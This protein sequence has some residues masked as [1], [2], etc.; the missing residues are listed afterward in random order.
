[1]C[2]SQEVLLLGGKNRKVEKTIE[3]SGPRSLVKEVEST[4]LA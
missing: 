4:G 3:D 2:K 1:L